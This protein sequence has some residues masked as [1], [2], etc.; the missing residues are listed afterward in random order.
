MYYELD[1][2]SQWFCNVNGVNASFSNALELAEID[3]VILGEANIVRNS[4]GCILAT[5]ENGDFTYLDPEM[6]YDE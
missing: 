5:F 6:D 1:C 3:S 4:D 2:D